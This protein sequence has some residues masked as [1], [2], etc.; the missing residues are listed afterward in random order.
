MW[1]TYLVWGLPDLANCA[2]VIPP[3]MYRYISLLYVGSLA[4]KGKDYDWLCSHAA[5]WRWQCTGISRILYGHR[6]KVLSG[7]M[8]AG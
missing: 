6:S 7:Y 3:T 4:Q 5:L 8:S 1:A 2:N